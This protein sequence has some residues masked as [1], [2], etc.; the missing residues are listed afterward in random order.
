[1]FVCEKKDKGLRKMAKIK[2]GAL[3][4]LIFFTF[5]GKK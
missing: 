4:G 3:K 1:M 2:T 5:N